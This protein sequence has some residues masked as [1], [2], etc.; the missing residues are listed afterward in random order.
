MRWGQRRAESPGESA[1]ATCAVT[2]Q[3]CGC[4]V[5]RLVDNFTM[6]SVLL[7]KFFPYEDVKKAK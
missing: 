6:K 2:K 3:L 5:G 1:S 7:P 4:V